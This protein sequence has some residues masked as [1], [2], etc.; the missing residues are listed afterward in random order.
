MDC[1]D[2][3]EFRDRDTSVG[4]V[5]DKA[6]PLAFF[7]FDV[8]GDEGDTGLGGVFFPD[9]CNISTS[10]PFLPFVFVAVSADVEGPG[11]AVLGLI[12]AFFLPFI[13]PLGCKGVPPSLAHPLSS[14]VVA[15]GFGATCTVFRF[16]DRFFNR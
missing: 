11:V 5:A 8:T 7:P 3:D 9:I 15:C 6:V 4:R 10:L 16:V 14:D 2:I 13:V 12:F 1:R